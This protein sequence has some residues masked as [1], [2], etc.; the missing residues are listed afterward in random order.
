MKLKFLGHAAFEVT[1]ADGKRIVFDPYESGSFGGALAYGPI[2][3]EYDLA[4]V[5]HD[6]AD[7]CCESVTSRARRVV[8]SA[9]EFDFEGIRITTVP[10]FHD[11]SKGSERG[12]NLIS[13]IEAEDVRIAHLGDLGHPLSDEEFGALEGVDVLLV[14]VGGYFT[15][16]AE[17]AAQ[18]IGRVRPRMAV[19]MHFKTPKVDFPIEPVDRFTD[20]MDRVERAGASEV[21]LSRETMPESS[22]VVVLDPAL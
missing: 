4:V 17:A 11:E 15:I 12:K 20:M 1:L 22:T 10:T 14:P 18:I 5:S 16:D 9:G 3:G 19:P 13:V 6:H 8:D 2:E 7:H 21:T